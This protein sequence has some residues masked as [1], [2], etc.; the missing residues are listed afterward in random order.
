MEISDVNRYHVL[1][2]VYEAV[3]A[4]SHIHLLAKPSDIELYIDHLDLHL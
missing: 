3:Y 1:L 2:P 4:S